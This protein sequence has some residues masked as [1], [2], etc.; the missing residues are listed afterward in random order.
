MALAAVVQA[1]KLAGGAE[2]AR[3]VAAVVAGHVGSIISYYL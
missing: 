3:P 2:Q 1:V